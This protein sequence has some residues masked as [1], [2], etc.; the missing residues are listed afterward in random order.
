MAIINIWLQ[1]GYTQ[2]TIGHNF[3]PHSFTQ[4][5]L[6]L[7]G[8]HDVFFLFVN[9]P[10]LK[11]QRQC[12]PLKNLQRRLPSYPVE[13]LSDFCRPCNS[14]FW[15]SEIDEIVGRCLGAGFLEGEM[16]REIDAPQED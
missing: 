6:Y 8:Q 2:K 3:Y 11:T 7:Q 10:L 13:F 16:G 4:Q 15:S 9:Q 14:P 5:P 1:F 12:L